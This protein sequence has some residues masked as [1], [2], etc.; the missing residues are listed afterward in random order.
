MNF[1]QSMQISASA[2]SAQT[3]RMNTLSSNLANVNTT[4][5]PEGGPY[6]P[7]AAVFQSQSSFDSFMQEAA[8]EGQE[9]VAGVGVERILSQEDAVKDVFDP[10][11]PDANE[12]GYVSVPDINVVTQM[13]DIMTATRAYEANV[14]GMKAAQRMAMK[15]L[16]IGG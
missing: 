2:L 5:T 3:V 12:D 16:E 8:V 13:T 7:K 15:A 10:S 6:Q 14:N 4:R 9:G 11:H 1:F